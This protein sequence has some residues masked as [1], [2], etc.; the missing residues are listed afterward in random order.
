MWHLVLNFY[1]YFYYKNTL[2]ED[3]GLE[4]VLIYIETKLLY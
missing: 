3:T 2:W 1:L 4:C